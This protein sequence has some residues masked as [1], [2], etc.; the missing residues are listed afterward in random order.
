MRYVLVALYAA[1]LTFMALAAAAGADP[2]DA[3]EAV[4]TVLSIGTGVP[5]GLALFKWIYDDYR[6]Q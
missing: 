5:L 3:P 1:T 2:G 6:G 4:Y